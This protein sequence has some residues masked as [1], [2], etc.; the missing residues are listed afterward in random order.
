MVPLFP[1]VML[2]RHQKRVWRYRRYLCPEPWVVPRVLFVPK[3]EALCPEEEALRW[4][5]QN[6]TNASVS[7]CLSDPTTHVVRALPEMTNDLSST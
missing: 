3:T 1:T 5:N 6:I 2:S 7:C 4:K